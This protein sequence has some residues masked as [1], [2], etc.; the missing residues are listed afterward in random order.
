MNSTTIAQENSERKTISH[1][2]GGRVLR[3]RK[4]TSSTVGVPETTKRN[5]A[6]TIENNNKRQVIQ[7]LL[8]GQVTLSCNLQP[9]DQDDAVSLVL[10]YKDKSMV[11]I[12]R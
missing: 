5:K 10:W 3:R 8:K 9:P 6:P 7:A 12:Y 2:R 4:R 1:N 11:P